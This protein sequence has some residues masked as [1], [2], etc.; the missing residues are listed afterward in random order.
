MTTTEKK[1]STTTV[2]SGVMECSPHEENKFQ[3]VL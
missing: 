2:A 1:K 3:Y